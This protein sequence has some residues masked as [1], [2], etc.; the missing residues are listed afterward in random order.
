[1]RHMLSWDDFLYN[2]EQLS[3]LVQPNP[4]TVLLGRPTAFMEQ[5]EF[6]VAIRGSTRRP[7]LLHLS[8][9]SLAAYREFEISPLNE[10]Q[11]MLFI[12]KFFVWK[13]WTTKSHSYE[14]TKVHNLIF[15]KMSP[16]IMD[17]AKRPVQLKMLLEI[18]P[19]L[20]TRLDSITERTLY[21][22]FVDELVRREHK[23]GA[24]K[25]FSLR[26]RR[27]FAQRIAWWLW[28]KGGESSVNSNQVPRSI[29]ESF[30][31]E[32][33]DVDV[34]RRDLITSS[35][36]STVQGEFIHFPHRS[37]QEFLVSEHLKLILA[38]SEAF[39]AEMRNISRQPQ[40]IFTREV[41]D[42]LSSELTNENIDVLCEYLK[43]SKAIPLYIFELLLSKEDH[44]LYVMQRFRRTS[45]CVC[46]I[47]LAWA[48]LRPSLLE[49]RYQKLKIDEIMNEFVRQ[50]E[51]KSEVYRREQI[52]GKKS[53][54]AF[55]VA[56]RVYVH[57]AMLYLVFILII[58]SKFNDRFDDA[59]SSSI[60]AFDGFTYT[61]LEKTSGDKRASVKEERE[62]Y[63]D[64][65]SIDLLRRLKDSKSVGGYN[66][67]WIYKYLRSQTSWLPFVKE[68]ILGET[69]AM[70]DFKLHQKMSDAVVPRKLPNYDAATR[71]QRLGKS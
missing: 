42:F 3:I 49:E 41:I 59:L 61:V 52:R 39:L 65:G 30:C 60:A 6:D 37:M 71:S 43:L 26:D 5:A 32:M 66:I 62:T 57:E 4:K 15:S 23:K 31:K 16:H 12:D 21:S 19:A 27:I 56:G 68:W 53:T 54:R 10:T 70:P 69:I 29:F 47:T 28:L 2:L 8:S 24:R 64:W 34:V 50:I 46:G 13:E 9:G 44:L 55:D 1:M 14:K 51:Q 20:S 11:I 17:I 67:S 58:S 33:D 40:D 18:L 45:D 48:T 36:L 63:L 35:F 25:K 38:N 7:D 22:I